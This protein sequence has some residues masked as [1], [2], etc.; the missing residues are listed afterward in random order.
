[1]QFLSLNK[2]SQITGM[3]AHELKSWIMS[4]KLKAILRD[5]GRYLTTDKWIDEIQPDNIKKPI[6]CGYQDRENLT[7]E[8]L[9]DIAFPEDCMKKGA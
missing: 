1:M 6:L 2:A 9:W 8:E 4:G 3:K 7:D 5:N